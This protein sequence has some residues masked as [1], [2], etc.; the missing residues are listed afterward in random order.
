LLSLREKVRLVLES[1]VTALLFGLQGIVYGGWAISVMAIPLLPYLVGLMY[2]YMHGVSPNLERD[3]YLLFFDR[4][5]MVG[6]IIGIVGVVIFLMAAFQ[7][8]RERAKGKRLIKTGLYSLVRH[9][10][11]F[12][13]IMITI[14]L[15]VM[16]L[17]I[18]SN[19]LE[20]IFLWLV[21]VA[22]YIILAKY[23]EKHL[24]K[25][26]AEQFRKYKAAVPFMLPIKGPSK[27]PETMFT[28]LIAVIIAFIFLT[29]PFNQL[30]LH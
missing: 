15:N 7:F 30:R 3:I 26:F 14:G 6:R 1:L 20:L 16:V 25:E 28:L 8:L 24:E 13:I 9:P 29:F 18:G 27:I 19:Q 22:G 5:F 23:E 12:G 2:D 17:T 11:Y 21:Q 4:E 10:Q